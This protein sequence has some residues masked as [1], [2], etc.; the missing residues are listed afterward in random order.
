MTQQTFSRRRF[1]EM[2]GLGTA[3]LAL[4]L[5][6]VRAAE[7]RRPN[8]IVIFSDDQGWGEISC[9]ARTDAP[10]PNIASIPANGVRFTDGYVSCPVCRPSPA[11]LLTGRYQQRFGHYGHPH[12]A[13]DRKPRGLPADY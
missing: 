3:A 4:P 12:P 9:N 11:G 13:L 10:T 2:A 8:V 6:D 7:I 1:L 5:R